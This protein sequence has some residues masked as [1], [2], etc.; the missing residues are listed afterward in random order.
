MA[1]PSVQFIESAT[2]TETQAGDA[3]DDKSNKN[4]RGKVEVEA[5]PPNDDG[6]DDQVPVIEAPFEE[7]DTNKKGDAPKADKMGVPLAKGDTATVKAKSAKSK[8]PAT[9]EGSNVDED[10]FASSPSK[11]LFSDKTSESILIFDNGLMMVV[12]ALGVA[13]MIKLG[14]TFGLHRGMFTRIADG[15]SG[16]IAATYRAVVVVGAT[17]ANVIVRLCDGILFLMSVVFGRLCALGGRNNGNDHRSTTNHEDAKSNGSDSVPDRGSRFG[18]TAIEMGGDCTQEE[19]ESPLERNPT[20]LRF[21]RSPTAPSAN[22]T[23]A[24]GGSFVPTVKTISIVRKPGVVK[25]KGVG[26]LDLS[27]VPTA[28]KPTGRKTPMGLGLRQQSPSRS[29]KNFPHRSPSAPGQP[30][31]E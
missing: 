25:S 16:G 1:A 12:M 4:M 9:T 27:A 10:N 3:A 17:A 21:G 6:R 14:S 11:R 26:G 7:E 13:A 31:E 28:S 2:T 24:P 8:A 5:S 30:Q 20:S 18:H 15:K 29:A 22:A 23:V 19:E